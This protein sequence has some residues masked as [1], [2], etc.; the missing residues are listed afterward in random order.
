LATYW[1]LIHKNLAIW[2]KNILGKLENLG[3]FF[4]MKYP[5]P[6]A[7]SFFSGLNLA[8]FPPNKKILRHCQV[9]KPL[10]GLGFR[11]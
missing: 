2:K 6:R 7:K 4:S 1:K 9:N 11:V 3:H 8:K 5:L 10:R